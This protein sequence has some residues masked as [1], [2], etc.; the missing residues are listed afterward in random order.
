MPEDRPPLV[1]AED[2]LRES[3]AVFAEA[4]DEVLLA[5]QP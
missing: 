3:I 2:A 4:C 1:I 5:G